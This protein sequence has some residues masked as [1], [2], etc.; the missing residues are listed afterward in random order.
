VYGD[1]LQTRDF[2]YVG[3]VVGAIVSA[4]QRPLSGVS[5]LNVGSGTPTSV[6]DVLGRLE[7]LAGGPIARRFEAARAGDI[8][9]SR[10]DAGRARWVLGWEPGET[11]AGGLE[12]T[13][14]WYRE[15]AGEPAAPGWKPHV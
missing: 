12:Q 6:L 8:R 10:A 5:V 7:E 1:G 2:V 13:W 15:R 3:D 14:A 9:D 4:V 11:F